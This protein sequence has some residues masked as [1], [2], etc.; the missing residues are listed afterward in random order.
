MTDDRGD[1]NEGHYDNPN[2]LCNLY[3]DKGDFD[4]DCY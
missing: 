4:Y 3:V 1:V 2:M